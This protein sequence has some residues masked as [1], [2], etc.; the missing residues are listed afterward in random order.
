MECSNVQNRRNPTFGL[1]SA[2]FASSRVAI[3]MALSWLEGSSKYI[4]RAPEN[5]VRISVSSG[6]HSFNDTVTRQWKKE[7]EGAPFTSY[8]S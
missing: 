6:L 8:S 7:P 4:I 3:E 5:M 1:H 2:K